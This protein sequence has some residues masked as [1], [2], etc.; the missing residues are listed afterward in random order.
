VK[1]KDKVKLVRRPMP[2]PTKR[3]RPKKGGPY[4]RERQPDP[5][6]DPLLYM[7]PGGVIYRS[8]ARGPEPV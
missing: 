4:R 1:A 5:T 3:E 7:T 2:P 8:T 6:R